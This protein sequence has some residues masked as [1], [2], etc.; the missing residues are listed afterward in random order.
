M[1]LPVVEAAAAAAVDVE[2]EAE[3]NDVRHEDQ[4]K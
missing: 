3:E 4:Q 2:E 1:E